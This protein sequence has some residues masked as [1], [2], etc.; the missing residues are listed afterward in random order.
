MSFGPIV[1]DRFLDGRLI[2]RQPR[3]GYRAAT[4]PVLLAAATP[5]GPGDAVLDLGCGVGTASLCLAHRVR[6][7]DLHGVEVQRDYAALARANAEGNNLPLTV[8]DADICA[9]PLDLR[10]RSFDAVIL[11]PPWHEPEAMGSPN[12]GRDR[13]NR[14]EMDLAIWMSAAMTRTRQGG[15]IV[16]I[17]RAESLPEILAALSTRAGDISVLPLAAR[18]DRPAKRVIVKA[19]KS[20]RGPFRL[21]APL[22]LHDG[23]S[24]DRD[25]DDYSAAASAVLRDGAALDF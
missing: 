8:Y 22:V 12:P 14:L 19:R 21:A 24:H 7:L 4:D 1:E 18:S 17:Q 2:L 13:A 20:S 9:M 6:D 25:G 15:W 10:H 11:N 16:V 5:A 3:H 23:A